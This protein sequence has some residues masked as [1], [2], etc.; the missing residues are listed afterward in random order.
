M[1]S[2]EPYV[3]LSFFFWCHFQAMEAKVSWQIFIPYGGNV[4]QIG[5]SRRL[6]I[7]AN[8]VVKSWLQEMFGWK[9]NIKQSTCFMSR[10]SDAWGA[11]SALNSSAD[12]TNSS[13]YLWMEK[14]LLSESLSDLERLWLADVFTVDG[15]AGTRENHLFVWKQLKR[16]FSPLEACAPF[17]I[18]CSIISPEV[19]SALSSVSTERASICLPGTK[20][21][22][23]KRKWPE[24]TGTSSPLFPG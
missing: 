23:Q 2:Y 7:V 12:E 19:S 22:A 4:T 11:D 18:D 21:L 9:R 5:L 16:H 1:V 10:L 13:I 20:W 6:S 8:A 15:W 24:A 3:T 17:L 14:R